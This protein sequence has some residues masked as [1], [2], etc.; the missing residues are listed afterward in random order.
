VTGTATGKNVGTSLGYTI[1]NLALAGDDAANY[2]LSGGSSFSGS[3]AEITARAL[4]VSYLGVDK[5]YDGNATASVTTDDDRVSGDVLVIDR[6]AAFADKNVGTGKTVN[7]TSV[8]LVGAD[9]D[10]YTVATSGSASANITRLNSVTWVGGTT[11]NWFDP[12]NWAGGAVPDLSNV[13]NVVIPTGVTVTFNNTATSPASAANTEANAVNID[14]L[15]SASGS[16]EQTEGFLNIDSGGMTLASYTQSGGTLTNE[17][18]TTLGSYT[19]SGGSFSGT[20]NFVTDDFAQTGGTTALADNFTVNNSYS[21]GSTGSVTVGSNTQITDSTGGMTLG[22]LATTGTTTITSTGGDMTQVTG[23]A[24]SSGGVATINASGNATLNTTGAFSAVLNVTGDTSLTSSGNL[25]VSGSTTG[26]TTTT[27]GANST[28]TFGATTVGGDLSIF[29]TGDVGQ[30]GPISAA[31]G[32]TTINAT[33][34]NV[35]LDNPGNDFGGTIAGTA[36]NMS[37]RDANAL[38]T[39]NITTT[40]NLTLQSNGAM[41]LGT[42]TVGGNL[43]VNSGNGNISQTGPADVTGT[44]NL[45]AG[46][47]SI[48]VENVDNRFGGAVNAAGGSISTR[49]AGD[50]TINV[51]TLGDADLRSTG[52]LVVSGNANN[53][54]T[55]TS[56]SNGI[57]TFGF[58]TVLGDLDVASSGNVDQT[59]ALIVDG[60]FNLGAPG[61]DVVLINPGNRFAGGVTN[62]AAVVNVFGDL[63][64]IEAARIAAEQAAAAEAARIAAEQAAAA[65]AA[66]IA[67]EQAAAAEAARI[68]TEQAAVA[69][70]ASAALQSGQAAAN[71]PQVSGSV[72][73]ALAASPDLVSALTA[74][75]SSASDAAGGGSSAGAPV[76]GT[77][78]AGVELEVVERVDANVLGLISVTLPPETSTTGTGFV[79][80]LPADVVQE[81]NTD[82]R[83]TLADGNPLPGW[84]NFNAA[85]GEF[86]ASAVPDQAFPIRVRLRWTG[87]ELLVVISERQ[88]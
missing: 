57:T 42:T 56:G 58:T 86:S 22:N 54:N 23:T 31:S 6:S 51:T 83:V 84:L 80:K 21:Q 10:N 1:S 70:V 41:S 29:S 28:T 47:G 81:F 39:G 82:L 62:N 63:Q 18:A 9:A 15:G 19:Q 2:H 16:L 43:D 69:D 59:G 46:T 73:P 45:N 88:T 50:L 74:S 60:N 36:G 53:L 66:R 27:T 20:G 65:E 3:D 5:V 71:V 75:P 48:T 32:N 35:V 12:A 25:T 4:T 14:S 40:G 76:S 79:F 13:A 87:Q 11:G 8:T 55:T 52:N 30:T 26:L 68:A 44:S 85:T 77:V 78:T 34:R 37:L 64:A 7:V 17:G 38:S 67:T 33:S 61:R 72:G 24:M 49:A